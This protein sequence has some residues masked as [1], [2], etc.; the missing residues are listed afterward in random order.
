MSF[1]YIPVYIYWFY[2]GFRAK[3]IFFFTASNP[4]IKNGGMIAASKKSIL[5]KIPSQ[6]IPKTSLLSAPVN[7]QLVEKGMSQLGLNYPLIF[8]PD[9]GER[10]WKV[11]RI[12]TSNDATE[13]LNLF[14]ADLQIQEYIDLPF[15][16]GVFYYRFPGDEM[17]TVSSIV[18]KELLFVL[19]DGKSTIRQLILKKPRARLQ[20]EKLKINWQKSLNNV[21][22]KGER[23]ELQPIGNHNR[24]TAFLNGNHLIDNELIKSFDAISKQIDGFYYGRYDV[25]CKDEEALKR[26]DVMIMELN[27]AASEPAHIYQSGYPILKAYKSLFHHWKVMYRISVD[28]HKRGVKYTSFKEGWN[29]LKNSAR[30]AEQGI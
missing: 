20:F 13:Y 17:G 19:G 15:E 26:G 21:P 8:K 18:V 3:S 25:R 9:L 10:G 12:A 24:G 28:N 16:A 14:S 27:G 23:V 7:I 5:D 22:A 11:E 29:A 30:V 1:F 6:Y 2:L 4:G